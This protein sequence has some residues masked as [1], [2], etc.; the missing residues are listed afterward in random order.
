MRAL[1]EYAQDF[2]WIVYARQSS[3]PDT[4]PSIGQPSEEMDE[5]L[6]DRGLGE[7]G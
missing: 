7:L 2:G 5:E 6:Q 4:T 3:E 1:R